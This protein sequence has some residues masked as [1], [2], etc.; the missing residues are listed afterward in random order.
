LN[1]VQIAPNPS[2]PA[3]VGGSPATHH[4]DH[5]AHTHTHTHTHTRFGL[6]AYT[7][8]TF[9]ACFIVFW[10]LF[11]ST[12]DDCHSRC[13]VDG[14][15]AIWGTSKSHHALQSG[16]GCV[17]VFH[18]DGT[19]EGRNASVIHSCIV[20]R[21][22]YIFSPPVSVVRTGRFSSSLCSSSTANKG[23]TWTHD[24]A[25]WRGPLLAIKGITV[26]RTG[27]EKQC[28]KVG[29]HRYRYFGYPPIRRTDPIP[30]LNE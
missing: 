26:T 16:L 17:A 3:L 7:D 2:R 8:E 20:P 15:K 24:Q 30:E 22:R 28:E 19:G 21:P 29:M 4:E 5:P 12:T 25:W 9:S 10:E 18:A 6:H 14:G 11:A 23:T 1:G 27:T 13:T